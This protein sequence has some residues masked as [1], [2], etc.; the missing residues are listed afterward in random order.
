MTISHE[1]LGTREIAVIHHTNCGMLT[2]QNED[3]RSRLGANLGE[4]AGAVAA[5]IDFLPFG[6]VDQSV[7][8][9]VSAIRSSPLIPETIPVR[10]FVYEVETGRLREVA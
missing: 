3:I 2:F 8:D 5:E 7:R 1:L 9:D 6:D 4:E 10:G